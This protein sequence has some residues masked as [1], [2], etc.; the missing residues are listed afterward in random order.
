LGQAQQPKQNGLRYKL[1]DNFVFRK[2]KQ[3]SFNDNLG[4]TLVVMQQAYEP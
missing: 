4:I 2:R 3:N 1:K